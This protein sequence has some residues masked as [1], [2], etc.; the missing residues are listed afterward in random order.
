MVLRL[1]RSIPTDYSEN[2]DSQCPKV[3]SFIVSSPDKDLRSD[4]V[5]RPNNGEHVP[6][7]SPQ[8]SFLGNA[9]VDYLYFVLPLVVEDVIRLDIPV[10][11]IFV[12]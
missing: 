7:G 11:N 4:V 10:A 3:N 9:K 12:V 1:E 8:E 5:V 2:G 6:P